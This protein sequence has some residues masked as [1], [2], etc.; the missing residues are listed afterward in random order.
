MSTELLICECPFVSL[1]HELAQEHR[2]YDLHFQVHVV[3]V[4]Q[5]AVEYYLTGLLEDTNLCAICVKCVT[6]MS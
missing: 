1:I 6:I 2:R 3:M 4:L 5:E